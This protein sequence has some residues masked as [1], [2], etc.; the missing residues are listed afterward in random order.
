MSYYFTL[1]L[2]LNLA[3]LVPTTDNACY[4][5]FEQC[6]ITN[7]GQIDFEKCD[8]I[9]NKSCKAAACFVK[10]EIFKEEKTAVIQVS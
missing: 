8:C 3:I 7:D 6:Q 4:S 9:S 5:C 2:I 10:V 1:Y